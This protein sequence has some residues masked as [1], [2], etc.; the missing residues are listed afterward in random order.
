VFIMLLIW[1]QA[2]CFPMYDESKR[3]F[4]SMSFAAQDSLAPRPSSVPEPVV[5][6][7]WMPASPEVHG[8]DGSPLVGY[9]FAPDPGDQPITAKCAFRH[10]RDRSESIL[11]QVLLL[12]KTVRH[13]KHFAT[14]ERAMEPGELALDPRYP[15]AGG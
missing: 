8:P 14:G 6:S 3:N 7:P 5:T 2:P 13:Q 12:Q 10:Q 11:G 9:M 1:A 15:T 4:W